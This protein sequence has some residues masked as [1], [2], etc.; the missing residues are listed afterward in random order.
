M[1]R[2]FFLL[3]AFWCIS[4]KNV[5]CIKSVILALSWTVLQYV[6]CRWGLGRLGFQT[7]IC[8]G[9]QPPLGRRD[10]LCYLMFQRT[11]SSSHSLVCHIITLVLQV[12][13]TIFICDSLYYVNKNRRVCLYVSVQCELRFARTVMASERP[14]CL[15]VNHASPAARPHVSCCG[16]T[17]LA[18]VDTSRALLFLSLSRLHHQSSTKAC[19]FQ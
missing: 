9:F 19:C 12:K 10:S 5:R 11:V 18:R 17:P 3:K 13:E 16:L 14:V 7:I 4:Y 2:Q 1:R 6:I 15:L 8:S